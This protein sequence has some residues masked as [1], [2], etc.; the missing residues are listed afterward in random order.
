MKTLDT[1]YTIHKS[2]K[3]I[4]VLVCFNFISIHPFSD[5]NGRVGKM[6]FYILKADENYKGIRT[7]KT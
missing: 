7:K 3:N 5:G 4:A 6:L 1:F 2:N